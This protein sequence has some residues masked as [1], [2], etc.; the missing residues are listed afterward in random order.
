MNKAALLF[1]AFGLGLPG[2]PLAAPPSEGTVPLPYVR[3]DNPLPAAMPFPDV[4]GAIP[5]ADGIVPAAELKAGLDA[6]SNG[7]AA[8]AREIRDRM[9]K[10]SLDHHILTWAIATSGLPGV[11][12]Y[13]IAAAQREL[14]GWPGLK[15]LRAHSERA[16]YW[17]NPTP[18]QVLA[19]FGKTKPETVEGAIILSRALVATGSTAEAAATLRS[20]WSSKTLDTPTEDNILE[21][22]SSLLTPADHKTRMAYLLYRSRAAQAKRFADLSKAQSFHKAW[23]AMIGNAKNAEALVKAADPSWANDPAYLFVRIE[24]LRRQDKYREAAALLDQAPR[25][26]SRLINT[27]EW[28]NE[29]RIIARGLADEGDFKE[30]YQIVSNHA[31]TLPADIADA[32]FHA[33]WYALRALDDPATAE[34]HFRRILD[35]SKRPLS[36]SRALYWLGRAAE[37]GGPGK[38]AEFYEQAA[39]YPG[40]FYGQLAAARLDIRTLNVAYPSPTAEDQKRLEGREA[41]KAIDLLE[42]AGQDRRAE[43][44]YKALAEE[45]DSPGE[46]AILTSR[47]E[48]DGKHN[49]SLEMGKAAFARGIDAAALAFPIGVIPAGADIAGSGKALAYAIA[50]QESAFNSGA[51]SVAN[52]RG[53]LQ[54]LPGTAQGV[55]KRHG[56][57]YAPAKLTSDAGYNATLGAHYLGEQI[58]TFGGSYILTFIAY[59]AGPRRVREWVA[60]YGDP[61]G[62]PLDEVI[63]WIER[64][65]FPETRNYVQRVMENYEVYKTRLGQQA[66]IESDLRFGRQ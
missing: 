38:A 66:E 7:D 30:A 2:L 57:S 64:I 52:A 60:R 36:A 55:A 23:S 46:L 29:R 21:E 6:V 24:L 10:G 42:S 41:V 5:R 31:A 54:L 59:N 15:S 58:D 65:P 1:T 56:L 44:L 40:T 43:A 11:P 13:E 37:A 14:A 12:S 19:A 35:A 17:E 26:A 34:K 16:L 9:T 63:D 45:I 53:L 50:R 25:E 18:K 3:P 28:W 8:S 33:G 49:L 27:T 48:R 61:R 62:K 51:V 22:F 20:I 47:A 39:R 4:T 32:E